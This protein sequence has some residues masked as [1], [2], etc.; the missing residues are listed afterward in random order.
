MSERAKIRMSEVSNSIFVKL[1]AA[2]IARNFSGWQ[3]SPNRHERPLSPQK[4][5]SRRASKGNRADCLQTWRDYP[6]LSAFA[7]GAA[8][9]LAFFRISLVRQFEDERAAI[10]A[11][12]SATAAPWPDAM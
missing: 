8:F 9:S 10:D 11:A 3:P 12:R 4:R 5:R 7:A 6:N 2:S 1:L